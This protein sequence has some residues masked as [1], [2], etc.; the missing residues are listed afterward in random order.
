[1]TIELNSDWTMI[2]GE[3]SYPCSVPCSAFRTLMDAGVMEDPYWRTNETAAAKFVFRK[4]FELEDAFLRQD[5]LY[6]TFE[7][8]DTLADIYLNDTYLGSCDNMHRTYEYDVRG[9]ADFHNVLIVWIHS[10][11]RYIIGKQA[12]RPLIGV[13][14]AMDGYPHLRKAHYMFGWDWG[15]K[16][17]DMGIWRSVKIQGFTGGRIKNVYYS[18]EHRKDKV[19]VKVTADLDIWANGVKAEVVFVS[20]GNVT[21][22]S[23]MINGKLTIEISD[24]QLWWVRGLGEQPLYI[25]EVR[26]K[27]GRR[28]LDSRTDRIGLRTLTVSRDKDKWGSEFCFI[29][30]GVKVF[31]MGANY[32]PEDHILPNCTKERTQKLLNDCLDANFNFIRVWGGGYYP[33]NSF[34]DFCDEHG[35]IVWQDFMFACSAY[36]LTLDFEATVRAEVTDNILR[37]R[38]HTSLGLWCGNNEIESAWEYWGWNDRECKEQY[39][40]LF[41][42]II[43]GILLQ[44]DP[45]TFYWPSSPSSGGGFREPSSNKSGDMHYWAVWHDFKPIEDFRRLY[46][47]FCSEYGFESIPD[48]K[49][50]LA[51]CDPAKRDLSLNSP[52]MKLHQKC[53][54]G[55]EKLEFYMEQYVGVARDFEHQIYLSQLVQADCIRSNVEHMRR[56]RGRCMGS[57]YW[58]LNDSNP[59]ISWSSVDYFGRRKALHY[60]A[61][62]FYAPLLL[63]CDERDPLHPTLYV[64]NDTQEEEAL[65][66]TCRI[67][68]N[69]AEVLEEFTAD[70][71]SDPLGTVKALRVDLSKHLRTE[72]DKRS[73]YL[74]Y[75]LENYRREVAGGTTLFVRPRDFLFMKPGVCAQVFEL[76]DIFAVTL[77]AEN[78]AKSVFLSLTE[79]D[80]LFSDNW[81]DVHGDE[82]VT[83]TLPKLPGL[84]AE[85]IRRQLKIICC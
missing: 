27:S 83:V 54:K 10:P 21:L 14:E 85:E 47:R 25:S 43:P 4:E 23:A 73:K 77:T 57:S 5:R 44:L 67:R 76:E 19:L 28:I 3:N 53:D 29:N 33:D 36:L 84:T 48:I 26:L 6:L 46:Y 71:I 42:E 22:T 17:P 52:V 75:K 66:V 40:Q 32:I 16:L 9:I 49:T 45:G 59:V 56:A 74:E 58:Q 80:C 1:M 2:D 30:N 78:F 18:Q 35:L 55:M 34:Y 38:N 60:F 79:T 61:K 37:L 62:R 68:N 12:E 39:L 8:I 15:A 41:E 82:E 65:T 51:F 64:T 50:C 81:F 31:A 11:V 69:L 70:I 13:K 7:G 72:E 63:S 20:P 24:P